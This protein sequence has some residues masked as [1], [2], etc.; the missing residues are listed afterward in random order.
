MRARLPALGTMAAAAADRFT[1]ADA[2]LLGRFA[3]PAANAI[4]NAQRFEA[5]VFLLDRDHPG[6]SPERDE[7]PDAA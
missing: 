7:T 3:A 1:D 2:A 4:A 5:V 6:H